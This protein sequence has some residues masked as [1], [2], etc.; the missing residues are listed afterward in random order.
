MLFRKQKY[1]ALALLS[2]TAGFAHASEVNTATFATYT[3]IKDWDPAVAF[4]TEVIMLSNVYEPLLWFNPPGSKETFSPALAKSWSVS[5]DGLTWEFQLR[6]GVKFHDGSTFDS[7][8][9]K[10]SI[11]RT[12]ELKK[13]AYYIWPK[14]EISTP[15]S[16]TL[17]IKTEKPSPI[18]LIASSQYGAY[19]YSTQA[20]GKVQSGSTKVT[21][22][23]LDHIRSL[24]GKKVSRC[25]WSKTSNTGAVGKTSSLSV[26]YLS[27]C[28]TLQLKYR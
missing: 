21:P 14:M 17:V 23:A 2:L 3:D 24:A 10:A 12:V 5:E 18:D 13:G 1:T 4:S 19:I 16:T 22:L 27:M 7:E 28:P 8:A 20:A 15:D 25:C 9:A 6:E 26:S 11:E